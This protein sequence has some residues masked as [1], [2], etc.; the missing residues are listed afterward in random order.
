MILTERQKKILGSIL[1]EYA[2][3]SQPVGSKIL[4]QKYFPDLSPATIRNELHRLSEAGYLIQLHSSSGRFPTDK[5]YKWWLSNLLKNEE[6]L[7]EEIEKWEEK[8]A[9]LIEERNL[10]FWGTRKLAEISKG[11]S[12]GCSIKEEKIYK[13]GLKNLYRFFKEI[14]WEEIDE[15]LEDI[16]RIEERLEM[17]YQ[18]MKREELLIFIGKESPITRSDHLSILARYLPNKN[19]SFMLLIGPKNMIYE[20]NLA[21][22]EAFANLVNRYGR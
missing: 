21:L 7:S 8:L 1:K 11:I 9:D 4:A 20:R 19:K 22:L 13:S 10:L 15:I 6:K 18:I 12:I 16:E 3:S 5:T 17:L 14:P 2:R